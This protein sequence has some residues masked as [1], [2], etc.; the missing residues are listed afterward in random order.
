LNWLAIH[1]VK[2]RM[3]AVGVAANIIAVIDISAKVATLCVQYAKEVAG[4]KQ[5]IERLRTQV[6]HLGAALQA[7]QTLVEDAQAQSLFTSQKLVDL[8]HPCIAELRRLATKLD[9]SPGRKTMRRIGIRALKWPFS[10]KEVDQMLSSLERHEKTILLGLQIDQT[11]VLLDIQNRIQHLS[12]S[13][14][15]APTSR[16]SHRMV[17]FFPDPDF[18]HRPAIE[19]WMQDQYARPDRRMALVGMGGFG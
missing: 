6:E 16:K 4:A 5:D 15:N 8:F 1:H 2:P 10:S 13:T 3:E 18:V 14:E 17:P 9:P 19:Q 12:L 7:A 11:A